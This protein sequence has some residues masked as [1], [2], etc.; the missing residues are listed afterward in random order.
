MALELNGT[1]GVSAV[2][3]GAVESGDLP[4]GS[5]IQVVSNTYNTPTVISTSQGTLSDIFSENITPSSSNN[6][7]LV[8]VM[9]S[10]SADS[11]NGVFCGIKRDGSLIGAGPSAGSRT[12]ATTGQGGPDSIAESFNT[13]NVSMTFI[14][15]PTTQSQVTYTVSA[16]KRNSGFI[17]INVTPNDVDQSDR[18]R[19]ISTITLMEI[20][21]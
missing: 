12:Q 21:G 16:N 17:N 13:T 20:A 9:L 15:E 11:V 8:Q 3:A 18:G 2:Q 7:I 5:V 4:A 6:K 14:D 19:F 1:T 10:I